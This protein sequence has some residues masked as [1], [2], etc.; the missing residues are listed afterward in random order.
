MRAS[1]QSLYWI[2]WDM[3]LTRDQC[4]HVVKALD[5]LRLCNMGS[6]D[7]NTLI[8][9]WAELQVLRSTSTLRH[10]ISR[11]LGIAIERGVTFQTPTLFD[12]DFQTGR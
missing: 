12:E 8:R 9:R 5:R 1:N 4:H 7:W 10:Q 2:L 11:M 6:D 3:G